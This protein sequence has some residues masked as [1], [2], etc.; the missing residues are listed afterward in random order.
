MPPVNSL[1]IPGLVVLPGRLIDRH[2]EHPAGEAQLV[3]EVTSKST[4]GKDRGPKLRGYARAGVPLY[5]IVDRWGTHSDRG[6]ATL[7]S[8]PEKGVYTSSVTISFG[9]GLHLSEPFDLRLDTSAFQLS[10]C[11]AVRR[12]HR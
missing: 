2:P 9:K 5:L 4:A 7:H 8:G 12:P 6:E 1:F 3:V 10:R 11:S